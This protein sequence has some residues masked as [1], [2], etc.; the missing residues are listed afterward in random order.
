MGLWRTAPIRAS[1]WTATAAF[2]ARVDTSG[3]TPTMSS[4][5]S[6]AGTTCFT[7]P[8]PAMS[9]A[10]CSARPVASTLRARQTPTSLKV[11]SLRF[12]RSSRSS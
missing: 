3:L 9:G 2:V 1:S 5:P 6:R 8:S 10:S 11:R 12:R 4:S 7:I